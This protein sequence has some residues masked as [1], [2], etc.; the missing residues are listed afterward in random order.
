MDRTFEGLRLW[1]AAAWFGVS[2]MFMRISDVLVV[3]QITPSHMEGGSAAKNAVDAFFGDRYSDACIWGIGGWVRLSHPLRLKKMH[4]RQHMHQ[5]RGASKHDSCSH[6]L[7]SL[8]LFCSFTFMHIH[9]CIICVLKQIN[10]Y[11]YIY[12]YVYT[13]LLID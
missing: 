10:I 12:I 4:K 11:I 7:R 3:K 2:A 6:V 8:Y 13:H 5:S 1:L 9:V